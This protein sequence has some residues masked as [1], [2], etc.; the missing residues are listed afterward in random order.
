MNLPTTR[1]LIMT[2][3]VL[4][5]L[6]VAQAGIND[7]S[8]KTPSPSATADL[9]LT[10]NAVDEKRR[11]AEKKTGENG[12][13]L[14]CWQYGRLIFEEA[15]AA[16]PPALLADGLAFPVKADQKAALYLLDK[17]GATCLVK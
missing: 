6:P 8:A 13:Y 17:N 12:H 14:R 11:L 4:A 9:A 3:L 16:L 15:I 2:A 1:I 10:S 5:S 7:Q